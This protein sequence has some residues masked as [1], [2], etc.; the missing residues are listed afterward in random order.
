M[1]KFRYLFGVPYLFFMAMVGQNVLFD[2]IMIGV[3][4][5]FTDINNQNNDK[6][7]PS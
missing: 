7:K 6:M 4:A 2:A 5:G 3:M 1:I